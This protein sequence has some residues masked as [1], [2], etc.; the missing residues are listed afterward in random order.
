VFDS[1]D[2]GK[3]VEVTDIEFNPRKAQYE[4]SDCDDLPC[5]DDL[6]V[7]TPYDKLKKL[8]LQV[9]DVDEGDEDEEEKKPSRNKQSDD[10]EA[11]DDEEGEDEPVTAEDAGLE[12]GGH[13]IVIAE[14][15]W[16]ECEIVRISG[17]GTSLTVEDCDGDSHKGIA[18][19]E[20]EKLKPTS[21]KKKNM[22][23]AKKPEP[24]VE[25]D[26]DE[27]EEEGESKPVVK[28]KKSDTKPP[29]KKEEKPDED[30]EEDWDEDW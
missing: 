21:S 16:G 28:K 26:E 20:V 19:D 30:E 1:S 17:D 22:K 18:C 24:E 23:K 15:D 7:A 8:F 2:Q 10:E 13:V 14:E 9:D 5:L 27:D 4:E 6:L 25:E 3:W 29:K 12:E 11:E